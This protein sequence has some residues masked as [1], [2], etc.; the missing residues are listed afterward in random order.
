MCADGSEFVG[1]IVIGADGIHSRTR[2]EMQRFAD[3]IGPPGLM[4][5]DKL[6][7]Y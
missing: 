7:E 1:H 2:Q 6:S 5:K 4:D 3:E